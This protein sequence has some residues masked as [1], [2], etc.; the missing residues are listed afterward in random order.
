MR[1]RRWKKKNEKEQEQLLR[2]TRAPHVVVFLMPPAM[3]VSSKLSCD[4]DDYLHDNVF[5][6]R[7][8][9]LR[10]RLRDNSDLVAGHYPVPLTSY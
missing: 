8:P 9:H 7:L 5:N 4:A 1:T 3:F 10:S 2:Y 6:S